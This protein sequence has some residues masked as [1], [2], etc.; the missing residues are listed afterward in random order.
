MRADPTPN[1]PA[2]GR[3][4]ASRGRHRPQLR[5]PWLPAHR[6]GM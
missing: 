5:L 3:Q 1:R 4:P 6:W 2:R